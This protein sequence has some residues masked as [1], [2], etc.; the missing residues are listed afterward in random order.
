MNLF[1]FRLLPLSALLQS[2]CFIATSAILLNLWL[3]SGTIKMQYFPYLVCAVRSV[4]AAAAA[5]AA[6]ATTLIIAST[7]SKVWSKH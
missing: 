6:R 1:L 4:D 2:S 7:I 5:A 3:F